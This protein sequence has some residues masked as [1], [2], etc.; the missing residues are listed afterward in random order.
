MPRTH[1]PLVGV[2]EGKA[3]RVV[4][5]LPGYSQHSYRLRF[6]FW[7]LGGQDVPDGDWRTWVIMAGRGFGKTRAGAEWVLGLARGD[8]PPRDGEGDHAKHGG[9]APAT[10]SPRYRLCPST[11]AFGGGPPPRAGEDLRIALVAAT[12]DEARSIMIDGPSGIIAC[13]RPGEIRDWSPARR[14]LTFESG[15]QALLYSG[16]SPES[17]R[18]PEHDF[19]WCDELAKWR[20]P[21]ET[22]DNLQL[23]LRRGERPRAVVTTT[24]K[25]GTVLD[26]IL[27]AKGTVRTGG[28]TRANRYLPDAYVETVEGLYAGTRY[29]AQELDGVLLRDVE[30]SLWPAGLIA[31]CRVNDVAPASAGATGFVRIVIGVDPPA[32]VAGTCGIVVC[33]LGADERGYVLDDASV[34]GRSPEGWARA[35]V[36][37]AAVW[38]ADR[39]VVERNQGGD[40]VA[41]VLRAA[42]AV[43]PIRTVHASRGKAARAE[44]VAALFESGRAV[45]AGMFPAL[46]AELSGLQVGGGY[47]PGYWA[48]PGGPGASPDRADAMVWA[49]WALMLEVPGA[50]PQ[51]RLL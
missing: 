21:K 20:H 43:L 11:P 42:N 32:S 34:T 3:A 41:S 2:D 48:G 17:L 45:F 9:G 50:V 25:A 31:R 46:E 39:V 13:A 29:G 27:A 38:G 26:A 19:A 15:A 40:M 49:L 12:V 33:G 10:R 14:A 1:N 47:A 16:A 6:P 44:P 51:I 7:E 30:G 36:E 4:A 28:S 22:W 5:S 8:N 18:G 35:V 37:A 23:G 24:P